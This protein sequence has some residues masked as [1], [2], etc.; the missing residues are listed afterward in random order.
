[1][2]KSEFCLLVLFSQASSHR[3][4][5]SNHERQVNVLDSITDIDRAIDGRVT[6]VESIVSWPELASKSG[7]SLSRVL[8]DAPA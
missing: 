7:D 5:N 3:K 4:C 6:S 8:D 1:M 2:K